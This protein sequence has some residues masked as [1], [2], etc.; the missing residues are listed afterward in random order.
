[1]GLVYLPYKIKHSW[2]DKYFFVPLISGHTLDGIPGLG[3]VTTVN[4]FR[5]QDLAL[6]DPFPN[7][8]F[9]VYKWGLPATTSPGMIIQVITLSPKIMVLWKMAVFEGK[10]P[11]GDTPIFTEQ[12]SG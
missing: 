3:S 7:G 2:I 9:M 12:T 6:W 8:L 11:I 4:R 10:D 1:M 5:P